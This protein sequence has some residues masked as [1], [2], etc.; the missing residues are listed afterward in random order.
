MDDSE[1]DRD[2]AVEDAS[3]ARLHPFCVFRGDFGRYS[4]CV[5]HE[6]RLDTSLRCR[7]D[8]DRTRRDFARNF[9]YLCEYLL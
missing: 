9:F 2:V 4:G 8:W 3:V 5:A 1:L 7:R 6:L